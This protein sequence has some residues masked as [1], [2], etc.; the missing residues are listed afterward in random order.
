[1][2]GYPLT[3]VK[4]GTFSKMNPEQRDREMDCLTGHGVTVIAFVAVVVCHMLRWLAAN[5]PRIVVVILDAKII[6][7][8]FTLGR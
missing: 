8:Y 5:V 6:C 1:M 2:M 4:S 3:N 7:L